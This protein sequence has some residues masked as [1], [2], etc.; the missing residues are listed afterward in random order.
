MNEFLCWDLCDSILFYVMHVIQYS[1]CDYRETI[2]NGC[3]DW[4]SF[5]CDHVLPCS[6]VRR[7]WKN[8]TEPF[9]E[10]FENSKNWSCD[11]KCSIYASKCSILDWAARSKLVPRGLEATQ[12]DKCEEGLNLI[13]ADRIFPHRIEENGLPSYFLHFFTNHLL[14][15][16]ISAVQRLIE[17][18][19]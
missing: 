5:A 7:T 2:K 18:H 12:L 16:I 11:D 8:Q 6:H 10:Y 4:R 1:Q 19:Y 14:L 3:C 13:R 17:T 9:S 15:R